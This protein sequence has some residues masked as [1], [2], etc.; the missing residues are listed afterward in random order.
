MSSRYANA[1]L[2]GLGKT[3]PDPGTGKAISVNRYMTI[4]PIV[5]TTAIPTGTSVVLNATSSVFATTISNMDRSE[6]SDI[7][8][9][10]SGA[11]GET[12]GANGGGGGGGG[13]YIIWTGEAIPIAGSL[14]AS[15]AVI[16][17]AS[18]QYTDLT[19]GTSLYRAEN[20]TTGSS[21][22]GGAGGNTAGSGS[23]NETPVGNYDGGAGGNKG[24]TGGG[25]GGEAGGPDDAGNAGTNA[26]GSGSGAGGTGHSGADG[27]AGGAA[28]L[29][30]TAGTAPGGGGGGGGN[31]VAGG[32]GGAGRITFSYIPVAESN[33]LPDPT[34]GG[35][36][37][38]LFAKTLVCNRVITATTAFDS[39]GNNV[40][41]L[42]TENDVVVLKSVPN[43]SGYRWQLVA[44]KGAVLWA[45]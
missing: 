11:P 7:T 23:A 32:A 28:G 2:G 25:G 26:S 20:G 44:N 45:A 12:G 14:A 33:T 19:I 13:E 35:A 16:N 21:G 8:L 30:G 3:V 5:T 24:T 37:L 17:T 27:G 41:S 34:I 40:I 18:A 29:V 1:M 6:A 43:G 9:Y 4:V 15:T 39:T 31:G 36:W 10:G 42:D 38:Q 22:T